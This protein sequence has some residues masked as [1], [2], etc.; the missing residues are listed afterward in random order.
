LDR[1]VDAG[2]PGRLVSYPRACATQGR[3]Q[4]KV[5]AMTAVVNYFEIGSADAD[6]ARSFYESLFGWTFSE[7]SPVGYRMVNGEEGGLWDTSSIGAGTWAIFYVQVDDVAAAISQ[8]ESLGATVAIPLVDNGRI[9]FAHLVDTQGN[10]FGVWR[11]K[12]AA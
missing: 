9:E 7:P 11:P 6:A 10:R 12:Q 5:I 4:R 3:N 1:D 8:A 2:G